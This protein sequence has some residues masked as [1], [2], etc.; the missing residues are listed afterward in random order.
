MH[1]AIV[2]FGFLPFALAAAA[3]AQTVVIDFSDQEI[4]KP[5]K[6]FT[7][8]R[9]GKGDPGVWVVTE[10]GTGSTKHKVLAQTSMDRTGYRFPLCVYDGV[11]ASDVEVSVRFKP[12]KGS[13]DQAAGIVWRFVDSENYYIVRANALEDNVVLYKVEK[14]KRTDLPLVGKG[15][16]YGEK[17]KV[18]SGKWSSLKVSA[19]GERF[20]VY[21]NGRLLFHVED[22]TFTRPGMVGLWT[23]A[24]SYTLFDDLSITTLK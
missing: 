6:G 16:T 9:T 3:T 5:P 7:T 8:A 4:G 12:L 17:V 22:T 23:K 24:D 13:G 14:G 19:R 11:S 15:R 1:P 20:D 10:E 2:I 21:L 18:P